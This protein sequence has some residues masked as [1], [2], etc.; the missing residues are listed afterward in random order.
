MDMLQEIFQH[1]N[2]RNYRHE[3]LKLNILKLD[4]FY[5]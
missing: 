1:F 5:P 2:E 4:A 3:E